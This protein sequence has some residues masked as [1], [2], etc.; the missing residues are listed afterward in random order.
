MNTTCLIGLSGPGTIVPG[1]R[2]AAAVAVPCC[3]RSRRACGRAVARWPE[4]PCEEHERATTRKAAKRATTCDCL[5]RRTTTT[6]RRGRMMGPGRC[7]TMPES[8][9]GSELGAERDASSAAS[10]RTAP[11]IAG[12]PARF[13]SSRGRLAR[14]HPSGR[15]ARPCRRRLRCRR[16]PACGRPAT[17]GPRVAGPFDQDAPIG[18]G[19]RGA[20]EERR[21]AKLSPVDGERRAGRRRGPRSSA[22]GRRSRP[23]RR[24]RRG[25]APRRPDRERRAD[26]LLVRAALPAH[27]VLPEREPVVGEEEDRPCGRGLRA[28]RPAS[29]SPL[30][31]V[32]HRQQRL[33]LTAP[34]ACEPARSCGVERSERLDPAGLSRHVRSTALGEGGHRR[35]RE[36]PAVARRGGVHGAMRRARGE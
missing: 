18:D 13:R 33:A 31:R 32:V 29:T 25:R 11:R 8:T 16:S 23:D 19:R 2:R 21:D 28:P 4:L 35:R 3:R 14:A 30:D 9:L 34:V 10:R 7:C 5:P 27:P 24:A 20:T 1:R 12:P 26:A 17:A 22:P 6:G 36:G 15:R